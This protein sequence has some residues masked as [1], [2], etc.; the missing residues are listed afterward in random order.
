V[1]EPALGLLTLAAGCL[2]ISAQLA[3]FLPAACHP[4]CRDSEPRVV[5]FGERVAAWVRAVL[6]LGCAAERAWDVQT[7]SA[8]VLLNRRQPC[9][10]TPPSERRDKQ[11]VGR[12]VRCTGY[13]AEPRTSGRADAAPEDPSTMLTTGYGVP[14]SVWEE[15]HDR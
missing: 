7:N 13:Q 15:V 8:G 12:V 3:R 6:P 1:P 14:G 5:G 10:L 2:P 4:T 9:G 11:S